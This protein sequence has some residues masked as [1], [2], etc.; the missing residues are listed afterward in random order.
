[1]CKIFATCL[2][3]NTEDDQHLYLQAVITIMRQLREEPVKEQILSIGFLGIAEEPVLVKRFQLVLDQHQKPRRV[4][5]MAFVTAALVLF[6]VSYS[7]VLQPVS[8]PP[9]IEG[10]IEITPETSYILA[11]KDGTYYLIYEGVI[12]GVL[13]LKEIDDVPN[14]YLSII[15]EKDE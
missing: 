1:M 2:Q 6:F 12:S 7:V 4:P 13:S 10:K 8:Q 3:S 14:C 9:D 15:Y 5:Q 11:A